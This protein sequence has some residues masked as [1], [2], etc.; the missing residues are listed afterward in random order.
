MDFISEMES[1]LGKKAQK[2]YMPMQPGDVYQTNA[3]TTHLEREFN[4]QSYTSLHDG[5]RK[6]AEWFMSEDNPLR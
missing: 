1:V 2:E 4:Y 5:I 6:F 3:D